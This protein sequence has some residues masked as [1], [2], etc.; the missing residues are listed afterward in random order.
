MTYHEDVFDEETLAAIP[1][2]KKRTMASATPDK[3]IFLL[4]MKVM[5]QNV[6][7]LL[8]N[9]NPIPNSIIIEA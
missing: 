1:M 8:I 4:P 9:A 6:K 7:K 3:I 5:N 2:I